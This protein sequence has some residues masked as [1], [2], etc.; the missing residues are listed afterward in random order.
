MSIFEDFSLL[1]S[2]RFVVR[3]NFTKVLEENTA[4]NPSEVQQFF[5]GMF[6]LHL[7]VRIISQANAGYNHRPACHLILAGF[8]PG[9]LFDPDDGGSTFLRKFFILLTFYIAV[10]P[11]NRSV[12]NHH[13]ENLKSHKFLRVPYFG[14]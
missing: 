5:G 11:R 2:Q 14:I 9:L 12:H 4:S 10:R 3:S 8:P 7:Q 6:C 1:G 13:L